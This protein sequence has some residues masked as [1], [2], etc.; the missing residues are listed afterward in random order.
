MA[1]GSVWP[2]ERNGAASRLPDLWE[3]AGSPHPNR[4]PPHPEHFPN[5]PQAVKMWGS[6]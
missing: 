4:F 6:A 2:K 3:G 5:I 1:K